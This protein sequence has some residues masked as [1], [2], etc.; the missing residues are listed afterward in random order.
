MASCTVRIFSASS[1][2]ISISKPSSKAITSST[3]SRESAPKSSTNEALGVTSPSSTPSCS[4]IICF[5]FSSTA[6]MF[7]SRLLVWGGPQPARTDY[8][9]PLRLSQPDR[10]D[11]L[12]AYFCMF[13]DVVDRI[14]NGANFLRV[15]VRDFQ[16]EGLFER[17]DQLHLVE[18]VGSEVVDE[19]G[20]CGDFTLV[21]PELFGNNLFYL[22]GH[23][24][25]VASHRLPPPG[26]EKGNT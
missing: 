9:Q 11:P 8:R 14:L 3:V 26:H 2:G 7:S 4:T 19:R 5:T 13:V 10:V 22:F 1:S 23:F 16:V 18:R 21:D 24:F 17:H 12:L 25:L 6:A 20:A 15:L